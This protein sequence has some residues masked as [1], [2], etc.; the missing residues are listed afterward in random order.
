MGAIED[1]ASFRSVVLQ[2]VSA[3]FVES[4]WCHLNKDRLEQLAGPNQNA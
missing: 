4:V 2:E 3:K 1:P